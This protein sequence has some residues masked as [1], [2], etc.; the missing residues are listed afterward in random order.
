MVEE[1]EEKERCNASNTEEMEKGVMSENMEKENE[2]K[3]VEEGEIREGK[4]EENGLR[5]E[6]KTQENSKR[7]FPS[8][9]EAK[10]NLMDEGKSKAKL[11]CDVAVDDEVEDTEVGSVGEEEITSP[12]ANILEL[13]DSLESRV[14]AL[15]RFGSI[16]ELVI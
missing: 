6:E 13:L 1:G 4:I 5:E 8:E 3:L 9:M 14:E 2:V 7:E 11:C 12:S 15:R 10:A 16:S